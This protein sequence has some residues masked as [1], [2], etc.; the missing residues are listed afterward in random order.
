MLKTAFQTVELL[1]EVIPCKR[2]FRCHPCESEHSCEL[3]VN[4]PL[5]KLLIKMLD[6]CCTFS[7]L[8]SLRNTL[9]PFLHILLKY[10]SHIDFIL[11]A[12]G[13]C[14]SGNLP[15]CEHFQISTRNFQGSGS[16]R[17]VTPHDSREM[18]YKFSNY[19]SG[20]TSCQGK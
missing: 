15:S 1:G 4:L 6:K 17:L 18:L 12:S 20:P 7:Q 5:I 3:H 10:L 16:K 14:D 2:D 11:M 8:P 13:K 19:G 9:I